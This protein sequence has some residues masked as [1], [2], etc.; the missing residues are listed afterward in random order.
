[1]IA[2]VEGN[3]DGALGAGEEQAAA[4]RIFAHGVD[5]GIVGDAAG[6]LLPALAA[7][8]RAIDVGVQ[9]IEAEAI[10]G[11]IGR[12]QVIVRSF[13]LRDFA[14][15]RK[16]VDGLPSFPAIA[17]ELDEAVIGADPNSVD[18]AER[19]ANAVDDAAMGLVAGGGKRQETLRHAG[20]L[21]S[22]VRTDLLPMLA[23][24][25]GLEQNI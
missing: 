18:V 6:D 7:V 11:G 8:A 25:S 1:M 17:R 10:D 12:L 5:G 23:A 19:R 9:I 13:E 14:P 3:I 24:I 21:A 15:G 20:I 16:R 4:H 2:I 22:E